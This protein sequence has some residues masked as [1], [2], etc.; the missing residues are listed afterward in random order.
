MLTL[1]SNVIVWKFIYK[2][3]LFK[4]SYLYGNMLSYIMQQT[5]LLIYTMQNVLYSTLKLNLLF[6]STSEC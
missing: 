4:L 5:L 2:E 1:Y 3:G 6:I